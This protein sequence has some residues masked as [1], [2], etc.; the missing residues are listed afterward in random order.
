MNFIIRRTSGKV[1]T[2]SAVGRQ[3]LFPSHQGAEACESYIHI[4]A[5]PGDVV[6]PG[7]LDNFVVLLAASLQILQVVRKS[8]DF[9]RRTGMMLRS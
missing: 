8:T 4:R 9:N 3:F 2:Y 5:V 6:E 7:V 1:I